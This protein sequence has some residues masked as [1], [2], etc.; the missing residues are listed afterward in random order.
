M[1]APAAPLS[2]K[3]WGHYMPQEPQPLTGLVEAVLT[4]TERRRHGYYHHADQPA[5]KPQQPPRKE[6]WVLQVP[7]CLLQTVHQRQSVDVLLAYGIR[8]R[9]ELD[10]NKHDYLEPDE[11]MADLHVTLDRDTYGDLLAE[12]DRV[13]GQYEQAT[14]SLPQVTI[15]HDIVADAYHGDLDLTYF[16]VYAAVKSWLDY[17]KMP[18]VMGPAFIMRRAQG[19][20]AKDHKP[21]L[22]ET[23]VVKNWSRYKVMRIVRQLST[24]RHSGLLERFTLGRWTW[25]ATKST[26][27]QNGIRSLADWAAS[28]AKKN[29]RKR[30]EHERQRTQAA[31]LMLAIDQDVNEERRQLR[32]QRQAAHRL[33]TAN[34]IRDTRTDP[35][36]EPEQPPLQLPVPDPNQLPLPF[37]LYRRDQ[38]TETQWT[39]MRHVMTLNGDTYGTPQA[40]TDQHKELLTRR[41]YKILH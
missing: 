2:T 17:K 9:G 26:L 10:P 36:Q 27:E 40:V 18:V 20:A 1:Y 7:L 4:T 25:Y 14:G 8:Y 22:P 33:S 24:G 41:G 3:K 5:S 11:I 32:E 34:K 37:R 23:F 38:V 15:Q 16:T 21:L 35:A 30:L 13:C 39:G 6:R 29:K 12:A 19:L 31:Q 28:I